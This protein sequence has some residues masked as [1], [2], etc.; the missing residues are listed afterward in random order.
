MLEQQLVAGKNEAKA[1]IA[2][3]FFRTGKGEYGEGD[4][5]LGYTVPKV[6][7]FARGCRDLSRDEIAQL[8]DS[9]WHEVRLLALVV[10]TEQVRKMKVA[11]EREEA[12]IWVLAHRQGINNWDL[13]DVSTPILLG[14]VPPTLSWQKRYRTLLSSPRLWDRRMGMLATFGWM[15]QGELVPTFVYAEILLCDKED[16]MHKAVGWMLR[17]AGK[18]DEGALKRFLEVHA[19]RMPRTMLRYAIERLPSPERTKYLA[20]KRV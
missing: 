9:P 17:E 16:L 3:R 11:S 18:R 1:L 8:L 6:R 20:L 12:A 13:V 7:H 4:R 14:G 2:Q 19:A 15:R 5:F 10:L